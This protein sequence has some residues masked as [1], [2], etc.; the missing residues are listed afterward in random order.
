MI[1]ADIKVQPS[2]FMERK[3]IMEYA[4]TLGESG[5]IAS[6]IGTPKNEQ[7]ERVVAIVATRYFTSSNFLRKINPNKP[8]NSNCNAVII[9]KN[10]KRF[11]PSSRLKS[12]LLNE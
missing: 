1:I 4:A 3:Y 10:I 9:P 7:L 6:S 11:M 5:K 8:I 2:R 12:A